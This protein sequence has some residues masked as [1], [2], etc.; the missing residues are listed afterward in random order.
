MATAWTSTG[1]TSPAKFLEHDDLDRL[2]SGLHGHTLLLIG[3]VEDQAFVMDRGPKLP[4]LLIDIREAI[5]KAVANEVLF[6]PI[7]CDSAR[8]GAYYG[9]L[10]PITTSQV[11]FLLGSVPRGSINVGDLLRGFSTIGPISVDVGTLRRVLDIAAREDEASD[12]PPSLMI[13]LP[14][15]TAS[16]SE[17]HGYVTSWMKKNGTF[18]DRES[19][20][21]IGLIYRVSGGIIPLTVSICLIIV[22]AMLVRLQKSRAH[23]RAWARTISVMMFVFAVIG[24]LIFITCLAQIDFIFLML[25]G[26]WLVNV[27]IGISGV[28]GSSSGVN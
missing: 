16:G 24:T 25:L 15:N 4:P 5:D 23:L 17:F 10:K 13:R 28:E 27:C 20:G 1:H 12:G 7:G 21:W 8:A 18:F 14:F 9:F 26:L 6:L 19:L 22:A 11:S 3:H 2:M